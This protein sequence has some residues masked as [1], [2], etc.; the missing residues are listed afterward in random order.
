MKLTKYQKEAIVRAIMQD[1]PEP[2]KRT[3]E[4]IQ[5]AFV[6]AMSK[7]CRTAYKK[8]PDALRVEH[9]WGGSIGLE[10]GHHAFIVGDADTRTVT[11]E[12]QAAYNERKATENKLSHAIMSCTT[13]AALKK[14][15]PE[16]ID[17]FPTE[18]QPT[19]NLPALANVVADLSKLGWPKDTAKKASNAA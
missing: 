4:E 2:A 10:Y 12:L 8:V 3:V 16:F 7:D 1:V 18:E 11:E 14:M 13:L 5:A 6:K 9:Y 17:Y 15:F 19:K